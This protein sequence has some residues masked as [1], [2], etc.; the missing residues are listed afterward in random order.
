MN[1]N[2][3]LPVQTFQSRLRLWTLPFVVMGLL[4][5]LG[6]LFFHRSRTVMEDQ[7]RITLRSTAAAAA[8][9]FDGASLENIHDIKDMQLPAFHD[10]VSRLHQLRHDNESIRFAYIVRRTSDPSVVEFIADADALSSA[11]ELDVNH[12]K[13]VDENEKPS[14]PG[15]R[16]DV[17]KMPVLREE[18]FESP[19]ADMSVTYDQW[20]A[21]IS[22]YAPIRRLDTGKIVAVLGIDM[23]AEDF[24]RASYS[25]FSPGALFLV[26][27]AIVSL[28][29]GF[30]LLVSRKQLDTL[31]MINAER[32][33]LL[34][35]TFHQLGEPLTIFKWSLEGLKEKTS[36][37]TYEELMP[38]HIKNMEIGIE[39]IS[40]IIDAL[41]GAEQVELRTLA[42]HPVQSSLKTLL[43]KIK[44]DMQP[45]LLH[46]HQSL[47]LTC[48]NDLQCFFDPQWIYQVLQGVL[49]NAIN[50]SPDGSIITVIAERTRSHVLIRITDKGIGIPS[51]D[52]PHIFE[53]F[54]RGSNADKYIP[55]GTGLGL[56]TAKGIINI[57][58]GSM[59]I[60]SEEG[61]GTTLSFTLPLV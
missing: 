12:N 51:K 37:E 30:I 1:T 59:H 44:I 16:Y 42:Y 21:L 25:I 11:E 60:E 32:T 2:T 35:L 20:G 52:L 36:K 6:V 3:F 17:S 9:Q 15:E 56:Y 34:Q 28:T 10:A 33:G 31:R 19:A 39:R 38:E 18:A 23:R 29:A 58:K 5:M 26:L 47:E 4:I 43:Q 13:I 50:Y 48:D 22:G 8:M 54:R 57:A 46:K 61:S 45:F 7:M 41:R 49:Q 53:K 40:G 27:L 55:A 24:L 14:F